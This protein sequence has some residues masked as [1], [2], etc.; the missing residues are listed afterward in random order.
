MMDKLIKK[1][2]HTAV[3]IVA[4]TTERLQHAIDDLVAKGKIT[5]DEG[6]KVV[7]DVVKTTD[8]KKEEYEGKFK[9]LIDS[10]I[11]KL[12]FS[13]G[14]SYE[15]LEKRVKSLEVKLGLLAKELE[16]QRIADEELKERE[17]LADKKGKKTK[18][19]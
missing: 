8:Y 14:E 17:D 9:N 3:G 6:R 18:K 11:A 4:G 19:K 2:L 5:A 12:N 10:V 1:A 7:D 15:K 13:Q 16:L